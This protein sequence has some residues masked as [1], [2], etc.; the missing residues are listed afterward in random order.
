MREDALDVAC[1]LAAMGEIGAD[2]RPSDSWAS[3]AGAEGIRRYGPS[4]LVPKSECK[5]RRRIDSVGSLPRDVAHR[6]WQL[7]ACC[8]KVISHCRD[9]T[10]PHLIHIRS[11]SRRCGLSL[12]FRDARLGRVE[13]LHRRI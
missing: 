1:G 3:H 6:L 8:P 10:L 11:G 9:T 7:V 12:K 5:A 2:A 4:A 13:V